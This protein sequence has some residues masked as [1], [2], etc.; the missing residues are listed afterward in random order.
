[1][2]VCLFLIFIGIWFHCWSSFLLRFSRK[3]CPT[4]FVVATATAVFILFVFDS[5]PSYDP[6]NSGWP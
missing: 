1:M 4:D 5:K 2:T 3:F 6:V